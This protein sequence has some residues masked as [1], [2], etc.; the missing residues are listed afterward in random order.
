MGTLA[1][2]WILLC[3]LGARVSPHYGL[4]YLAVRDARVKGSRVSPGCRLVS[5]AKIKSS[6]QECR[7][8]HSPSLVSGNCRPRLSPNALGESVQPAI[9]SQQ[10]CKEMEEFIYC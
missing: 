2:P 8:L 3:K 1:S 4:A 10:Q 6:R 5:R 7:E 9:D